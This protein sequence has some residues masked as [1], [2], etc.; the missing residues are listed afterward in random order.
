MNISLLDKNTVTIGD[1]DLSIFERL[2]NVTYYD[3]DSNDRLIEKIKYSDA[4]LINKAIITK[5]VIDACENLKFIGL[6]ATGYN[7]VDLK[8]AKEKGIVVCNAP[9]YSTDSVVQHIFALLLELSTSCRLYDNS[10]R[11]GDWVLSPTFSYF[12]FPIIEL[13][14]KTMGVIGFGNIGKK[15]SSVAKAF[16][17]NVVI[18]TRTVPKNSE[19]TFLSRE[20]LFKVSDVVVLCCPLNDDTKKLINKNTLSL[21]K[22]SAV[23]INTSRGGVV[24]ENALCD[25]LKNNKI[26]GAGLDVLQEE[27]MKSN[28]V[29]KGLKNCIITP[30]TAWASKEARERLVKLVYDNLL[31]FISGNI[32]NQV[33]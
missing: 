1:V 4:I 17:M 18:S 20:E 22:K 21:M 7:N 24:D 2:G 8:Y 30:H 27:P 9:N 32:Q 3:A 26:F 15:V 10:V 25:A 13:S 29:L 14:H 6:F 31:G 19:Y 16:G 5:D 28:C 33:N 11:N 12:P 23:L